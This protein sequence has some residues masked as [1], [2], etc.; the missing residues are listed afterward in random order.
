MVT[1][2]CYFALLS[3]IVFILGITLLSRE[4]Q[5]RSVYLIPLASYM[6]AMQEK[7]I[8]FIENIIMVSPIGYLLL[9]IIKVKS[10]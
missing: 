10:K 5:T 1:I 9:T 3:V 6:K 8:W 4:T 2:V 7:G